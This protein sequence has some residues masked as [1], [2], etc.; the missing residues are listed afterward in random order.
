[1]AQPDNIFSVS[2]GFVIVSWLNELCMFLDAVPVDNKASLACWTSKLLETV[3]F[4]Q[5]LDNIGAT[6]IH[7]VELLSRDATAVKEQKCYLREEAAVGCSRVMEVGG[8]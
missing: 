2:A 6:I 4:M 1:M 8:M 7:L 5:P 3:K